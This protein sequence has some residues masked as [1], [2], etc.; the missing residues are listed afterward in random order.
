[1]EFIKKRWYFKWWG[2]AILL[3]ILLFLIFFVASAF[4]IADTIKKGNFGQTDINNIDTGANLTD[5]EKKLIEGD[6]TNYWLGSSAA[7]VHI[8]QFA[9][10]GCAYC[11]ASFPVLR[12]IGLKYKNEVKIVFRDYPV[13]TQES[14]NLALAARCA[15]EQGMFWPMHDKLYIKQG[16]TSAQG[17]ADLARQIGADINRFTACFESEKYLKEVE[18]DLIDGQR[19]EIAGTP[20][21]FINGYRIEGNI[22]YAAFAEILDKLLGQG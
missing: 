10:F 2:I 8:I 14:V 7:K 18:K 17:L 3:F 22:P 5:E 11:A 4:Y 16:V 19:L 6:G 13:V 9:D 20:A 21:W 1:M 15:G 12:E